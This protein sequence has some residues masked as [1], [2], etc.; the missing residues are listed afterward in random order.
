ML[1]HARAAVAPRRAPPS[2]S[3]QPPEPRAALLD[4]LGEIEDE[5]HIL[6]LGR[7]GP[8]LMCALLRAGAPQVTHLRSHDRLE[9]DSASLVIVP[10]VPSLDW[11]ESALSSIRRAL[12]A[13]GRLAVCVDPLPT[14][15][16]RVH[17]HAAAARVH[18]DPRPPRSGPPGALRRSARDRPSPP[19]LTGAMTMHNTIFGIGGSLTALVTPFRDTHV[20][21]TALSRLSE[22]QIDRGTAALIVCGS[23]GEAASLILSEYARAVHHGGGHGCRPRAGDRRLHRHGD[24]RGG[25]HG[26]RGGI[27]RRRRAALRG[28]A[29]RE[30]DAGGHH[31]AYPRHRARDRS[32]GRALRR[33]VA[34]RRGDRRRHRGAA[35]RCRTDRRAEGCHRRCV[36]TDPAARA[37]RRCLH[38]MERR[39]RDRARVSGDGWHRLHL[40]HRQRGAGAV[41]DAAPCLGQR[42]PGAGLPRCATCWI[43]C[44]PRCSRRAIRSR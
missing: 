3:L 21:W 14:T 43:L 7:D 37:V 1:T 9:A 36:A 12:L 28:A 44:T 30:A 34:L 18:R 11:L 13:N 8:D 20:D 26:R 23:T 33:S 6:V 2:L 4:S 39:R 41:R 16:T 24:R 10:H 42:R 32:S 22:R 35:A 38:A 17:T 19:R 40:G 31:R 29:L 5:E 27:R 15:Q 25:C